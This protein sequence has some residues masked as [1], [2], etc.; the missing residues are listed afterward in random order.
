MRRLAL[1][2]LVMGLCLPGCGK[3]S[4][5]AKMSEHSQLTMVIVKH[6]STQ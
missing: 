3:A 6:T 5:A 1:V 4:S 2:F